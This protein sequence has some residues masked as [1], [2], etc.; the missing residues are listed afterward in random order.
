MSPPLCPT[1]SEAL[2]PPRARSRQPYFLGWL[3]VL[4]L[5]ALPSQG[6]AQNA[7]QTDVAAASRQSAGSSRVVA[8]ADIHGAWDNLIAILR[9]AELIDRRDRW[10]GGDAI[11][12]QT[13]DFIDR[14]AESVQVAQYLRKLQKQAEKDGGQVIVLLGNHEV[15]NLIGDLRYVTRDI[16]SAYIDSRS[17]ARHTFYCNDYAKH[18]RRKA[19]MAEQEVPSQREVLS[20]CQNA[21]AFGLVEYIEALGPKG[22]LGEWMRTLPATVQIGEVVFLHGGLSPALAGRDLDDINATVTRQLAEFDRGR[23]YL[24]K[25][26]HILSTTHLRDILVTAR[27]LAEAA[28]T[29]QR[30]VPEPIRPLLDFESSLLINSDGPFWFRGYA[31]WEDDE[32]AEQLDAILDPLGARRVVVGHTPQHSHDIVSRFDQR[33]FLIDT[34]MLTTYYKGRASALE[35]RDGAI[36]A[37]YVDEDPIELVPAGGDGGESRAEG[38]PAP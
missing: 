17:E 9:Q 30:E 26:R 28:T 2:V 21:Q 23:A 25:N 12:V 18:V 37:L 8:I 22:E 6:L 35:F 33:V 3:L 16:L 38:Q 34:G 4:A 31:N 10:S 7:A 24:L 5:L 32:G 29:K 15:L 27:Q 11:L 36:R 19:A 20:K 1:L 13:G 14:G